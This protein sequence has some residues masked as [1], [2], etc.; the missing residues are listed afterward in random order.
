[1][2]SVNVGSEFEPSG[3]VTLFAF[4]V[5][6]AGFTSRLTVAG[7]NEQVDVLFGVNVT[8]SVCVPAPSSA[9]KAGV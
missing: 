6:T 1:M 9:F 3:S 4:T 7:E 2:L 5:S 8:E